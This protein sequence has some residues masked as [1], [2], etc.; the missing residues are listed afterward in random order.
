[1]RKLIVEDGSQR[2]HR[3]RLK[4]LLDKTKG[5]VR[6]ASA[7]VT[8]R[9]LLIFIKSRK[10][11]LLTSLLPMDIASGATSLET[12]GALIKSGVECRFLPGRPR[13][14]AKV[15][16]FGGTSAVVTS[17]NLTRSAFDSNIEV[18]VEVDG[19]DVQNLTEWFDTFW[20]KAYP[21]TELQLA[22]LEKQTAALRREYAKLKKKT[23][24]KFPL[25]NVSL[26]SDVFSDELRDL[27]EHAKQLFVCNTDRRQGERTPVG[28]YALEQEMHNR[29]YATA[30]E[31][32]RF[33]SHIQQ[34]EPGDAIFM[35][36]KGIG[37]IGIGQAKTKCETLKPNNPDRIGKFYESN[38][39][40]WRVPVKWLVWRDDDDAYPYKA[41]NFTF[42]NVTGARYRNLRKRVINHFLSYP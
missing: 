37:I 15:Y 9:D 10:I 25:P 14:H 27:L 16:I 6:I 39:P 42:W 7:Y 23:S 20:E 17:A 33:P 30:W 5:T 32:F 41:P 26:P 4:R 21:R 11:R 31:T 1:M 13:L 3:Q 19:R 34:V 29:G 36:A 35:F 22:N 40:E 38:T 28:G 8:D 12:L 24:E 18:G 2:Q